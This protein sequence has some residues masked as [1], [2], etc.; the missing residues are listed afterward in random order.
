MKFQI[1]RTRTVDWFWWW[2]MRSTRKVRWGSALTPRG[3]SEE[4]G[5][6]SGPQKVVLVTV[7]DR[8]G[9]GGPTRMA[10]LLELLSSRSDRAFF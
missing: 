7:G 8:V 9:R 2:T 4:E 5:W 10:S 3:G 1:N 6:M